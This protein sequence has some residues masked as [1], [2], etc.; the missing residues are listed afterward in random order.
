MQKDV[1]HWLLPADCRKLFIPNS[2]LL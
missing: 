1:V 2:L